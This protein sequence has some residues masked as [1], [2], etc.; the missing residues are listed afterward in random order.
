MAPSIR[1]SG[2]DTPYHDAVAERHALPRCGRG[3]TRP[4]TTRSGPD[5]PYHDAVAEQH[6][7]PRRGPGR[8]ALPLH[9][10][11]PLAVLWIIYGVIDG[12]P[13]ILQRV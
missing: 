9:P 6:V 4:N 2:T 10:E 1:R 11:E 8:T 3:A 13:E 12:G 5:A 7:L